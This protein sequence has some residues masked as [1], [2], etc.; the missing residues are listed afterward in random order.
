MDLIQS[1]LILSSGVSNPN[2]RDL[3]TA[4]RRD[5][6]TTVPNR[7]LGAEQSL[8]EAQWRPLRRIHGVV[9]LVAEAVPDIAGGGGAQGKISLGRPRR[10][11]VL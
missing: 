7:D 8:V 3:Y 9:R 4:E 6:G 11:R 1:V 2:L 10:D 5:D